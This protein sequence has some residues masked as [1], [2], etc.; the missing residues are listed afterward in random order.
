MKETNISV[1]S[2]SITII[3]PKSIEGD[4]VKKSSNSKMGIVFIIVAL[5]IGV[6]KILKI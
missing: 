4:T 5:I 2:N 6:S 1:K 3:N